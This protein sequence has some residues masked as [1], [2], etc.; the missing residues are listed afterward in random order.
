MD[1]SFILAL[2]SAVVAS[3]VAILAVISPK[4]KTTVDDKVLERLLALEKLLE[5]ATKK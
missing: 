4:T 2:G 3:V 1:I 5:G